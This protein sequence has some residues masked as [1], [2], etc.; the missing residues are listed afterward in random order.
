MPGGRYIP[1]T[2]LA[3]NSCRGG[4]L[5]AKIEPN[6]LRGTRIQLAHRK[7]PLPTLLAGSEIGAIISW[8]CTNARSS[9]SSYSAVNTQ[10]EDGGAIAPPKRQV[11]MSYCHDIVRVRTEQY[12]NNSIRS[13]TLALLARSL[14]ETTWFNESRCLEALVVVRR[15]DGLA[16]G[17]AR[18][19]SRATVGWID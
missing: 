9:Y 8:P 5:I 13:T 3:G 6:R 1:T 10:H 17:A 11:N 19:G 2:A 15:G 4:P 16:G 7:M 12:R 14:S 18:A